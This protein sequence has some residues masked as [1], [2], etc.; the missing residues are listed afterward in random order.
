VVNLFNQLGACVGT[1][2]TV[3]QASQAQ[4]TENITNWVGDLNG[5]DWYGFTSTPPV[6][7]AGS[8]DLAPLVAAAACKIVQA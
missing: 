8:M 1:Y 6:I 3:Q 2:A 7:P 5:R 4:G